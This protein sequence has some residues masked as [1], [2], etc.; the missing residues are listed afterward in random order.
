MRKIRNEEFI[1]RVPKS[2]AIISILTVALIIIAPACKNEKDAVLPH[3]Q[4]NVIP[5]IEV[6]FES[7]LDLVRGKRVGL[8]TNPTG[9]DSNLKSV[10]DLF[11][12]N[13]EINLVALYGPEHGI[14]GNAQAGE[15]VPFYIDDKY[16]IPVFSLYGQSRKPEAGMLKNIDEYMR[17]FDTIKAGKIPQTSM[18][19]STDV[20]IFDIQDVGT[21]IYTYIATMAYCM[22]A[23]AENGVDFIVLDRPNPING[24]DLEGPLLE[25][26]EYSSFVGLYPIPIR[27]GMT[28]GELAEYFNDKFL[29]KKV[30]LTVIP[31]QG[32]E[33]KMWYDETSLPWVIPSPNMPTLDTATVYPGQEFLEGTNIS[34]GRGTTKPFEIFG[35]PWIDGYELTKKLNELNLEG[36][37]FTEA[38]FSPTFSKYEGELCGGAQVHVVDRD[39]YRPFESSLHIIKTVMNMYPSHFK[40]HNEYFDKLMGTSKVREALEK[41]VDV[42]DIIRSYQEGLDNFSELRK[43]YLLY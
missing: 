41:G 5:G 24:E 22:Q 13:Q 3:K 2:V 29:A 10:I 20:L 37:K 42:N 33:R 18:V 15:Y 26:P 23:C 14:R 9:V 12:N 19:E 7:R 11:H 28:I 4:K 27:H 36:I 31:M 38:W 17:S 39:R 35:A 32:W 6:F 43:P 21:R 8:I 1:T 25:Y 34:E 30:N 16:N 40:F